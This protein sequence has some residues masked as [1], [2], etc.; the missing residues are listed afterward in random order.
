MAEVRNKIN[1]TLKIIKR[2][3]TVAAVVVLSALTV[4]VIYVMVCGMNGKAAEIFGVSVLKVVTGSMEPSIHQGDYIL[5]KKTD[6]DSLRED[7]IICFYSK[8]S[9]IYGMPNTHRIVKVLD[10]GS[11]VTK[12]DANNQ[13]DTAAVTPDSIIGKYQGKIRFLRWLNSFT[14]L[15]KIIFLS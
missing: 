3:F 5:V 10:D 11:F 7:D 14:S 15:K 6:T 12:G 9:R 1:K 2:I 8:D 4:I 13:Q